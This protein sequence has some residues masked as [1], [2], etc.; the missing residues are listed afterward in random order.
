M[1]P[2]TTTTSTTTTTTPPG[3]DRRGAAGSTG[4]TTAPASTTEPATTVRPTAQP[5]VDG[6]ITV[7][8][9]PRLGDRS[10]VDAALDGVV[11]DPTDGV[12][13]PLTDAISRSSAYDRADEQVEMQLSLPTSSGVSAADDLKL[14]EPGVYPVTIAVRLD[15]ATVAERTTLVRRLAE[16]GQ[17]AQLRL[18]VMATA[19]DDPARLDE[20]SALGGLD[21]PVT[22]AVDPDVLAGV[23]ESDPDRVLELADAL[24]GDESVALPSGDLGPSSAATADLSSAFSRE[25]RAGEDLLARYLPETPARRTLWPLDGEAV[26]IGGAQLL[27]DGGARL[28]VIPPELG[29]ALISGGAAV[30]PGQ[31]IRTPLSTA[32]ELSSIAIDPGVAALVT[33]DDDPSDD[34]AD[35]VRLLSWL[36]VDAG[37][38]ERRGVV[39]TGSDLTAPDPDLLTT[40]EG[41]VD[42]AA[43]VAFVDA[44]GL[45][46]V[47]D[48]HPTA[49]VTLPSTAGVDLRPRLTT[50][51][52][53][54]IGLLD[55]ASMLPADDPRPVAWNAQLD[56]LINPTISDAEAAT[57]ISSM[58]DQAEVFRTAIVPPEPFSFTLT[59]RESELQVRLT[60]TAD[61]RLRVVVVPASPRLRFPSG[62][63]TV[64]IGAGTTVFVPI[65]VAARAN[66]TTSVMIEVRTPAGGDLVG[67]VVLTAN[68]RALT[69]VGQVVTG[70]AVLVLATWWVSHLRARRRQRR[71]RP[72]ANRHLPMTADPARLSPDA[73]AVT[74]AS[75]HDAD[76]DTASSPA[77]APDPAERRRR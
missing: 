31:R 10:E 20:I 77:V 43:D 11:G 55:T 21:L 19:D 63:Q 38:G 56:A 67:P 41:L 39:I 12:L 40:L 51:N 59:G 37:P 45:S 62:P 73:A 28:L 46:G 25:W 30:E 5:P 49:R 47:S 53:A 65:D 74:A 6:A 9:H 36:L 18:G 50:V 44:S 60:N 75:D 58:E 66:G 7:V 17:G 57:R 64:E 70:G 13:I 24:R 33:P 8:V 22:V 54:R 23:A 32:A 61:T 52:L 34:L 29:D 3:R 1:L 27:S 35:S 69:G 72:A 76:V 14:P 26:S 68:V 48:Q 16:P 2:A 15:D 42:E 71:A 4:A